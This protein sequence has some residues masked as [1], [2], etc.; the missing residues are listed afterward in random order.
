MPMPPPPPPSEALEKLKL[1]AMA[2]A[3]NQSLGT[4]TSN[5][6]EAIYGNFLI[7]VLP[8]L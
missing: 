2:Q 5:E 6:G 3:N 8:Q 1:A 7:P 4:Y